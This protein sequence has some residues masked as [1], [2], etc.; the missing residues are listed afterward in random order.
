MVIV[1]LITK[2]ID[3]YYLY[4]L[5]IKKGNYNLFVRFLK[6][7]NVLMYS[8]IFLKWQSFNSFFDLFLFGLFKGYKFYLQLWGAGYRFRS[9]NIKNLFGLVLRLG[10]SHLIYI[11]LKKKFRV[12]LFNK[13]TLFFYTNDLW[14]L[15]NL[16][17]HIKLKRK[18]NSYKEK[19][20]LA[21][22]SIF[23]LK[24]STKLKF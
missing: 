21:K 22:N 16:I 15:N 12:H 2:V 5:F 23:N 17:S 10:Y 24:K 6:K 20:I 11:H 4:Y 9:I 13:L 3:I 7:F 19:G 1:K 8:N 18:S 14:S